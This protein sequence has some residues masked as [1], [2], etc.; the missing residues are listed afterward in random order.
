MGKE[1]PIALKRKRQLSARDVIG[2]T[3]VIARCHIELHYETREKV[4][5]AV[6][7]KGN[8][9]CEIRRYVLCISGSG[10]GSLR[11]AGPE[12]NLG[13]RLSE[14]SATTRRTY[15]RDHFVFFSRLQTLD[16]EQSRLT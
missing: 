15:P 11:P 4:Q 6:V 2:T 3:E 1:D 16:T 14:A 8:L 9:T 5:G 7:H 13:C 10:L 12:Q